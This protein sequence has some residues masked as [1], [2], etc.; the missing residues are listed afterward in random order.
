[1]FYIHDKSLKLVSS[2]E[3]GTTLTWELAQAVLYN[4]NE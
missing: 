2:S 4:Y 3:I 1:M